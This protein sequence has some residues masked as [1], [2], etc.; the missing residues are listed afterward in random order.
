MGAFMEKVIN[1]LISVC[2]HWI[3]RSRVPNPEKFYGHGLDDFFD[4]LQFTGSSHRSFTE[5]N[6]IVIASIITLT[7]CSS[8]IR[9]LHL[10]M[11]LFCLA[12]T[13]VSPR[14]IQ[15]VSLETIYPL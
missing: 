10:S 12:V 13:A 1:S 7:A 4:R 9:Y 14:N 3:L 2:H 5:G 8:Y 11:A 6:E 15:L